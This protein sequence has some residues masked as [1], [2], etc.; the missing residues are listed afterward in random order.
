MSTIVKHLSFF[1]SFLIVISGYGQSYTIQ[2]NLQDENGEPLPYATVMLKDTSGINM[3]KAELTDADGKYVIKSVDPGLYVIETSFLGYLNYQSDPLMINNN[4]EVDAIAMSQDAAQLDEVTITSRRP[5]IEVQAD[6]TVFNVENTLNATGSN[7]FEL[8]RKAP[9]VVIDNNDNVI[10]EGKTGVQIFINGKPSVLSADDLKIFLETLQSTDIDKIEIITQPSSKYDAAGNAGIINIQLK[11]DKRFGTNGSISSGYTQGRNGRFNSSISLNNRGSNYNA[12]GNYSNN[13]GQSWNFINLNRFQSGINYDSRSEFLEDRNSHNGRIGL[14]LFKG[15]NHTFGFLL[16][17]NL[18]DGTSDGDTRTPIITNPGSS[19]EQ[20]LIAGSDSEN[21]NYNLRFNANYR[22]A[23]TL[24]KELLVDMDYGRFSRDRINFQP[25]TYYDGTEQAILFSRD[26]RM[27][28]PTDIDVITAKVDY[29]TNG[30]GG[31]IG[32]GAKFS[33]VDTDNTFSFFDVQDQQDVLN[34]DRSNRFLYTEQ[35]NAAYVNYN[36]KWSKFNLQLGLRAEQTISEGDL[37][38]NQELDDSNVKRNYLNLFPSGGL[39]FTPNYTSMWSLNYSRRIQRPNYQSLN[40]FEAQMDELSFQKGNPFLQPQY[41]NNVRLAHTYKYRLTT[42]ISYSL[43]S[44][45]FAQITDT[46]GTNRNFLQQ[47]N[48]ANQRVINLGISYPF[49]AAKWW[50]VYMSVNAFRSSFE[51]DNDKFTAID[52]NTLS[53]YAQNTFRFPKGIRF[54]VSGWFSSPSVWG[55]TYQTR[56]LGSLNLAVQKKFNNDKITMRIAAN[57]ILYTSNWRGDTRFGDLYIDGN[58]GWES[59]NVVFN[60]SYAFGSNEVKA[61]RK[62][63]TGLED[64]SSRIQ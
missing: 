41:T 26:S 5:L 34:E 11:K 61:A 36:K 40:P 29:T 53:L 31:K 33:Y 55:G 52:Q 45:F 12:Y 50:S 8:L 18:Y 38:S 21:Q 27:I 4:L 42:S 44:D 47:R 39:T 54:E 51:S 13:L 35:I 62:R 3:I 7:G 10:L 1:F 15:D 48:I 28:T 49:D 57:D 20:I 46:L 9:G 59:R 6:R 43:I 23:D 32:L 63:T 60:V 2:G 64:E 14:D 37:T 30:L 19:P 56:S 22:Y 17:G 58:G 16:D 24:G 25:N